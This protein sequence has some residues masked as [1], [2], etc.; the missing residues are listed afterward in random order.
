MLASIFEIINICDFKKG[1]CSFT[2]KNNHEKEIQF[3]VVVFV[4]NKNITTMKKYSRI[5]EEKNER[6]TFKEAH[7]EIIERDELLEDIWYRDD[8]NCDSCT[9]YLATVR[10]DEQSAR[11]HIKARYNQPVVQKIGD[12][13]IQTIFR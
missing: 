1:I 7:Q 10:A 8:C 11:S 12:I 3:I 5:Q 6:R 4:S 13:F 9:A 2:N